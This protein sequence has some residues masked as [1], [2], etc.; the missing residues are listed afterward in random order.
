MIGTEVELAMLQQ[1]CPEAITPNERL[2]GDAMSGDPSLF[3]RQDAVK[4]AWEVVDPV[5]DEA[6]PLYS[7]EPG[8]WGP[9]ETKRL[10]IRHGGWHD[11]NPRGAAA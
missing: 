8:S 6:S 10:T 4:A 7:Y 1:P 2:L 5:L 3:A 9:P 11:P